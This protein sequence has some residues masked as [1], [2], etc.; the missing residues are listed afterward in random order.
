[1]FKK[2]IKKQI[3]KLIEEQFDEKLKSKVEQAETN[4]LYELKF[5]LSAQ[6]RALEK[7]LSINFIDKG[8]NDSYYEDVRY[9]KTRKKRK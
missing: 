1:M 6:L 2:F 8:R 3:N 7:F 9:T 5:D 4:L